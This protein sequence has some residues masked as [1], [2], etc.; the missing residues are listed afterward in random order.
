MADS[1]AGAENPQN[2]P[3][4][5]HD[6]RKSEDEGGRPKGHQSDFEGTVIIK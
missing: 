4:E 2:E 3:G 1:R 5:S 6:A